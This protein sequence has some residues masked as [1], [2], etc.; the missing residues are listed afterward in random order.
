MDG[1]GDSYCLPNHL[2]LASKQCVCEGCELEPAVL[3]PINLS[4]TSHPIKQGD[5]NAADAA[6]VDAMRSCLMEVD[7]TGHVVIDK[8]AKDK[9]PMLHAGRVDRGSSC[10]L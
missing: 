1:Q 9:A 6:A 10:P 4:L 7:F 3:R 5:K 2:N 8:G